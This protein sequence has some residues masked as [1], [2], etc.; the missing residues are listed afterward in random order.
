MRNAE[1]GLAERD[2]EIMLRDGEAGPETKI[3]HLAMDDESQLTFQ[4]QP[5]A[6]NQ[7]LCVQLCNC[8]LSFSSAGQSHVAVLRE[9]VLVEGLTLEFEKPSSKDDWK[10]DM[11]PEPEEIKIE[12]TGVGD[13]NYTV[14]PE[15]VMEADD[16]EA[17]V[18]LEDGGG[19]L[20]LKVE[21]AMKR[22]LRVTVTPH[23]KSPPDGK[24]KRLVV[25][26]LR[27]AM[28][29]L[30]AEERKLTL[31][32]Q[33]GKL[34]AGQ[35]PT[36]RERAL[37]EQQVAQAEQMQT[38][39]QTALQKLQALDEFLKTASGNIQLQFRVYYEADSS[40]IDLLRTG[41]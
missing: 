1:G 33:Q 27:T 36:A 17:W 26:E 18:D 4:W 9:P 30:A 21:T 3:A 37:I 24:P 40:E 39:V 8:A 23:V 34:L 14:Q 5:E 12:I 28:T 29:Q 20:T 16:G 7:T 25:K 13:A 11:P 2:W 6:K 10:I 15:P 35:A 38:E 32:V 19:L 22:T 31:G 41:S